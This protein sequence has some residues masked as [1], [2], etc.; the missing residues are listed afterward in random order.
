MT[1]LRTFLYL[2]ALFSS[3]GFA[4]LRASV[5]AQAAIQQTETAT[6]EP[7]LPPPTDT[8]SPEPTATPTNPPSDEPF[9]RPLIVVQSYKASVEDITP[10]KEFVL[11]VRLANEGKDTATNIVAVFASGDFIPRETGGVVAVGDLAADDRHRISQPLTTSYDLWGKTV[12]TLQMTVNYTDVRGLTYHETFSITFPIAWSRV[13]GLGATATPTPTLTPTPSLRPQ[14]VITT[15]GADVNPLRPG[16]QFTLE[17]NVQNLGNARAK[18]V[19][20]ILGGGSASGDG[21]S[22]TPSPGG[23]SAGGSDLSRFAPLGTSNIQSL[24][25]LEV[26]AT[27]TA[28]QKL[29]VNVT[30]EPGAYPLMVSFTYVD[31]RNVHFTDDQV[32]T[33]LVYSPPQLEV[34]FYRDPGPLMAGQPNL[35]PI[36][37]VNLGRKP[38]LLGNMKVTAEGVDFTNN[39]ILVGML[40]AGNYFTLDASATPYQ[41]GPLELTVTVNYT[42][43]FNQPQ[44]ISETLA[45]EVMEA[46]PME[47]GMEG[48]PGEGPGISPGGMPGESPGGFETPAGPESFW[49]KVVRFLRGLVGLDSG[50]SSSPPAG[51]GPP[52]EPGGEPVMPPIKGP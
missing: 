20:M 37:V 41:P 24:G 9:L 11:D 12:A 34:S 13:S 22:G 33:L 49:Q 52:V 31:D 14:L 44:Q 30:T 25:D 29:I 27:I 28:R 10:G 4:S 36:Q 18:Q 6:L 16:G 40:E 38:T 23:L 42:D 17:L 1:F 19:T 35:L 15:Y 48:P 7:T 43:D 26:G 32:I 2:I 21:S 39:L 47:P 3:I 8:P 45:V 5:H 50:R 46:P 51:E